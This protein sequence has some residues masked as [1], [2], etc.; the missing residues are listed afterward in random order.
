MASL[1]FIVALII[2]SSWIV[3]GMSLIFTFSG[4]RKLGAVCGF[5]SA[6]V[7]VWMIC[8]LP[9]VPLLGL[10]NIV[11]GLVAIRRRK[12]DE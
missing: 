10:I 6:A 1:A 12:H 2:I 7:G 4:F 9:H 11:C 5:L 3:A 8:V